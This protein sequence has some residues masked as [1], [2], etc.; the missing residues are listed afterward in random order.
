MNVA[1]TA[2]PFA[3]ASASRLLPMLALLLLAACGAESVLGVADGRSQT[4]VAAV[5]Q[6]I[7]VTLGSVGPASFVSPPAISSGVLAFLR[8]DVVS[9]VNPGGETQRFRFR[10]MR[11]GEAIVRFQRAV[12]DSLVSTVVDTVEVR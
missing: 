1:S 9:P 10:A 7:D 8:S 2:G 3:A 11:R 4:I 12:G 5:G 6:E